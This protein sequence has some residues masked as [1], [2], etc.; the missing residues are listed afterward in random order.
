MWWRVALYLAV[1]LIQYARY[2]PP[3]GP[4]AANLKD[5]DIPKSSEG[6]PIY[7]GA[8]TFWVKDAHVAWQGDRRSSGIYKSGGKK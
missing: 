8:G 2:K 3:P 5:L 6:D 1:S 7:D 4:S